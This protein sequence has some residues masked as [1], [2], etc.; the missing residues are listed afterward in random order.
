M[1]TFLAEHVMVAYGMHVGVPQ[2]GSD[3]VETFLLRKSVTS[4]VPQALI[5]LAT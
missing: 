3:A 4:T 5:S 1:L 2:W